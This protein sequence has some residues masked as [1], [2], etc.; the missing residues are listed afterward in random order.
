MYGA[1]ELEYLQRCRKL[2]VIEETG[3]K[4]KQ[5]ASGRSMN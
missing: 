1:L 2:H 3:W 5:E 4:R